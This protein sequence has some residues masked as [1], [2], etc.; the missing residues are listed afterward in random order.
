MSKKRKSKDTFGQRLTMLLCT[1]LV[2]LVI[3]V[4]GSYGLWR[5]ACKV[6]VGVLAAWALVTTVM[7]P[8]GVWAGMRW[9][10]EGARG[11]VH[12]LD[13]GLNRAIQAASD[14]GDVKVNLHQR[15]HMPTAQE[16]QQPALPPLPEVRH[17]GSGYGN[18]DVIDV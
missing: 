16:P 4:S 1:A 9:G 13:L 10:S 7:V 2:G 18:G 3:V 11:V 8:V 12:G 14:I 5:L 6:N 17:L 15:I